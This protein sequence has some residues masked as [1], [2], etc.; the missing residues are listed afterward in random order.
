MLGYAALT[1]TYRSGARCHTGWRVR[2]GAWVGVKCGES[3]RSTSCAA[4]VGAALPAMRVARPERRIGWGERSEDQRLRAATSRALW[5]MGRQSV[6]RQQPQFE[7]ARGAAAVAGDEAQLQALCD[8]AF[9]QR[10]GKGDYPGFEIVA[11]AAV[12]DD[13]VEHFAPC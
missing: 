3:R 2:I 4:H 1:P 9:V 10:E 7:Q 5:R 8:G 11:T 6:R 13:G 12:E